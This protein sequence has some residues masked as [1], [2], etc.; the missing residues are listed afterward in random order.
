[1]S[2]IVTPEVELPTLSLDPLVP[3]SQLPP[4]CNSLTQTLVTITD[5]LTG[6]PIG[7][8]MA[9]EPQKARPYLRILEQPKT[10]ALRFRYQCEGRGAGALQ[11]ERSTL[12]RKSYPRVQICNYK[13]PAVVV[14]SCVTHDSDPRPRAH[15]HNLV[16]PASVGR[17]GCKMGV[18][19]EYVNSEDM[20]VEFPHLGIQCVRK[21]D[22]EASLRERREIRVDPFRQGFRHIENTSSIDLNAV[23]LCFQAFLETP[24][25]P[26][27]YTTVLD[28]V[29]SVPVFDAKA[30]KELVIMDISETEAPV[31]GGKKII[32]LCEKVLRED[33]KVRF[34]DPL[35]G[36]EG[37]GQFSAQG[38]H[39]QVAI[40]LVTPAF[41]R[42][43]TTLTRHRVRL[44]LVRPSDEAC[45]EPLDFYFT[46]A[47]AAPSLSS[48]ADKENTGLLVNISDNPE[49]NPN[50]KLELA[51]M[52][53]KDY[54]DLLCNNPMDLR[55][56]GHIG[57]N[58]T[59]FENVMN[60]LSGK[61]ESLSFSFSDVIDDSVN[62][63]D[64]TNF[65]PLMPASEQ[66]RGSVKRSSVSAALETGS[67]QLKPK[68]SLHTPDHSDS[69]L[70]DHQIQMT[71]LLTNC[72]RINDL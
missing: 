38:V 58:L 63:S 60:N 31:E 8:S 43:L 23:K 30:K 50:I 45:S 49:N 2:A 27:K 47:T 33:I 40:S 62:P 41:P 19:K 66:R 5:P 64:D 11:G 14:V 56:S 25:H 48:A 3:V 44:E 12:E 21:K 36:W 68:L 20:T 70:S 32:I 72:P 6:L 37:W 54:Q 7:L 17:G 35:S 65:D 10:N 22:V 4:E 9:P 18:C 46:A 15:P 16:S 69:L 61:I 13:G 52:M 51:P 71:R 28:P 57:E 26:G 29:C 34:W 55:D 24:G 59:A 53:S 42:A 39:K 1:M 67:G